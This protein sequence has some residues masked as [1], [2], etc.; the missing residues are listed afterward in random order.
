VLSETARTSP[1]PS[2]PK[3]LRA[4]RCRCDCGAETTVPLGALRSGN[5][6][7]CGCLFREGR[8]RVNRQRQEDGYR[9]HPLRSLH[10]GIVRRCLF[11]GD[12]D[13]PR[14]GGRGVKLYGPWRSRGRFIEDVLCEI[15]PRPSPRH[16]I[17]RIDPNGNYEPGKIRWATP[18]EQKHNQ[19]RKYTY[20]TP[21]DQTAI[22]SRWPAESQTVLAF[23]F[24]TS[25][26][27]IGQVVNRKGRFAS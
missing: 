5:T 1:T 7:S 13:Y 3:G 21:E 4:F 14:Y 27:T 20:L 10:N 9:N 15:G 23:A 16:S 18:L 2:A 24:N 25:Q 11:P 19:R 8:A 22:R 12:K 26:H 6:S 17:D